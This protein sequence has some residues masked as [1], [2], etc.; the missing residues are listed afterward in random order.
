M[1]ACIRHLVQ[2]WDFEPAGSMYPAGS[3]HTLIHGFD[4]HVVLAV[5]SCK[6]HVVANH[7]GTACA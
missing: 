6:L 4:I 2:D 5:T 3:R 7:C 1:C